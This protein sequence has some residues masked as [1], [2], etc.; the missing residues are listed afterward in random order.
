MNTLTSAPVTR[1]RGLLIAVQQ[2]GID[3]D[4]M[5]RLEVSQALNELIPAMAFSTYP[6]V[7]VTV[8]D[9]ATALHQTRRELRAA[10]AQE[11]D[12]DALQQIS[13]AIRCVDAALAAVTP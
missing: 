7:P 1:A 5:A 6:A 13:L 2:D 3:L 4:P 9:P 12:L 10:I 8:E 11:N